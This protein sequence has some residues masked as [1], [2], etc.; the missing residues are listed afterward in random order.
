M[1]HHTL[2]ACNF[3]YSNIFLMI[4]FLIL[5]QAVVNH[6]PLAGNHLVFN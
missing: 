6:N 2:F 4:G 1:I 5:N 3:W